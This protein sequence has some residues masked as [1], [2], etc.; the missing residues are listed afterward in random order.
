MQTKTQ[1]LSIG[2][3]HLTAPARYFYLMECATPIDI[4]FI[5]QANGG[6]ETA[7]GIAQG[8]HFEAPDM[9]REIIVT[10]TVEQTIKWGYSNGRGGYDRTALIVL[11]P[12]TVAN[13]APVTVTTAATLIV[14]GEATRRLLT[15]RNTGTDVLYIGGPGVTV[16]NAAYEIQPGDMLEF[17]APAS[18]VYGIVPTTAGPVAILAGV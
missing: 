13:V 18:A 12:S 16:A 5:M 17:S 4:E 1:L 15:L 8:Y 11:S 10:T 2:R 7:E 14:A 3:H 6:K 9:L